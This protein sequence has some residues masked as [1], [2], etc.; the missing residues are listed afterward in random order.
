VASIPDGKQVA[1]LSHGSLFQDLGVAV[2]PNATY[3][4]N[5]SVG[6]EFDFPAATDNYQ[7]S[8]VAGGPSGTVIAQA[9][10]TLQAKT[11]W[12]PFS[13][14]GKGAG[15]GNVGVLIT[16]S[17]GQ[18]LFDNVQVQAISSPPA[19]L[20]TLDSSATSFQVTGLTPGSMPS[21]MIEAFNGSIVADSNVAGVTL[22]TSSMAV[23]ALVQDQ[24]NLGTQVASIPD[25]NKVGWLYS[26][27]KRPGQ[28]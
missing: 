22:P 2:D 6:T 16:T 27:G 9:S 15:S 8:L 23:S 1:W 18:P 7:V 24:P 10:G 3:Q 20:A 12:V 25:G 19:L 14:S 28:R 13:I 17:T 4:L 5:L 11:S 21:F 26:G